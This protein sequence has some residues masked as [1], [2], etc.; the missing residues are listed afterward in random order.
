MIARRSARRVF[1]PSAPRSAL[2]LDRLNVAAS[3]VVLGL[4]AAAL[5]T[6]APVRMLAPWTDGWQQ[7]RD[8][9]GPWASV[10]YRQSCFDCCQAREANGQFEEGASILD[11]L[12]YCR[13]VMPATGRALGGFCS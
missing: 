9:C 12:T 8:Y 10:C 1:P 13:S 4:A 5:A 6:T 7:G 2:R 11:C 3:I